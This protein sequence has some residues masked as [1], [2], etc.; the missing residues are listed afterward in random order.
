MAVQIFRLSWAFLL[1]VCCETQAQ[2]PNS[3]NTKDDAKDLACLIEGSFTVLGMISEAKDCMENKGGLLQSEFKSACEGLANASAV[4]GGQPGKVSYLG[5]CPKQPIAVCDDVPR[6]GLSSY[7][8]KAT[9]GRG[10]SELKSG[11]A[12]LGGKA[13]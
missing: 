10:A 3:G 11:C 9:P 13:R 5:S 7:Y 12:S 2:I 4:M 1:L 8:Y 6:K